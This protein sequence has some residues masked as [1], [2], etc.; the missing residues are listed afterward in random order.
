MQLKQKTF[1]NR[2]AE[3][4]DEEVNKFGETHNIK[5]SQVNVVSIDKRKLIIETVWFEE[6]TDND[7]K[8][9]TKETKEK[10]LVVIG[11]A[12][13]DKKFPDTKL[14]CK[15]N[16]SG[17]Y[18]TVEISELEKTEDGYIYKATQSE[19]K[20]ILTEIPEEERK[21]PKMPKYRIYKENN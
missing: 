2:T 13:P 15:H 3:K 4:L 21:N 14:S 17:S 1:I 8:Q 5:F 9:E 6:K 11:A 10:E 7:T 18:K 20:L 19:E 12:W 16:D